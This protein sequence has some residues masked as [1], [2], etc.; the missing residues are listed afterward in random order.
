MLDLKED[1]RIYITG[2]RAI[3]TITAKKIKVNKTNKIF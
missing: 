1:R 3:K 2:K